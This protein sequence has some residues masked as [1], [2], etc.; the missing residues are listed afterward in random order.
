MPDTTAEH[1]AAAY[2][3]GDTG[4]SWFQG[5]A[6]A[7]LRLLERADMDPGEAVIDIGGGASTFVDGLLAAGFTD[8]T[9]LDVAAPALELARRRL[10]EA[11]GQIHWLEA[12]ALAW[13]P[14]RPYRLWH[15]RA[16]FHFLTTPEQR[17]AYL[18]RLTAGTTIGSTLVMGTFG[19]GGPTSCSGLP[20]ERYDADRLL[21]TLGPA[22]DEVARDEEVHT[23]PW[24][25]EQQFTWVVAR[26]HTA[27]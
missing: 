10:G 17:A 12:D 22:W 13:T 20:V 26:R 19:P 18:E 7:S 27:N 5:T 16:V 1:W 25:S 23:T 3:E 24:G 9:V 21:A 4:K 11:A 14:E 2:A 15:D 6:T 8:V